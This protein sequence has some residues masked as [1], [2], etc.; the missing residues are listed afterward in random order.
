MELRIII[1][2]AHHHSESVSWS[3]SRFKGKLALAVGVTIFDASKHFVIAG[4]VYDLTKMTQTSDTRRENRCHNK[5][6]APTLQLCT[7][8]FIVFY[9]KMK[10]RHFMASY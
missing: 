9:R 5:Y 8:N 10:M 6:C 7:F 3:G 1:I 2:I 4:Y